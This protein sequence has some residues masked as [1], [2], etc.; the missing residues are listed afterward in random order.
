MPKGE[1]RFFFRKGGDRV[2]Y[3]SEGGKSSERIHSLE[4]GC[5]PLHKG[6]GVKNLP[7]YS[8]R[9]GGGAHVERQVRCE[10]GEKDKDTEGGL[11]Y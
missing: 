2:A 4:Q 10:G 6:G 8:V 3:Y 5:P 9:G 7:Q 1:M 11:L